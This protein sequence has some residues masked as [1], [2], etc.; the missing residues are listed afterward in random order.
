MTIVPLTDGMLQARATALLSAFF[1]AAA[2]VLTGIGLF[3]LMSGVVSR[4]TREVGIR[5]ALGSR[6]HGILRLILGE[7][8]FLALTGA[9]IGTPCAFACARL[10]ARILF[11]TGVDPVARAAGFGLL[12]ST[13]AVAGYVP[14]RRAMNLEPLTALRQE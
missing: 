10:A 5:M 12:L 2:L 8:F 3:A 4:R 13:A 9:A 7:T 14:A 6:P 11:A 1:A